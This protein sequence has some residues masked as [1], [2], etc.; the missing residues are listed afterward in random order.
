MALNAKNENKKSFTNFLKKVLTKQI[1]CDRIYERKRDWRT[2]IGE[3][4][5]G[6]TTDSAYRRRWY[7]ARQ[8]DRPRRQK[9]SDSY[10]EVFPERQTLFV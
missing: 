9:G 2:H 4:C 6:S 5:N 10:R 7:I 3:L 1:R 8:G